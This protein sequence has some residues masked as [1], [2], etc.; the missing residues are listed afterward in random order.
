MSR[1]QYLPYR[2]RKTFQQT[3]PVYAGVTGLMMGNY[4]ARA[5]PGERWCVSQLRSRILIKSKETEAL[6]WKKVEDMINF[7]SPGY[8]IG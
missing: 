3:C 7:C 4:I 2:V 6:E 8:L 5:L 1:L